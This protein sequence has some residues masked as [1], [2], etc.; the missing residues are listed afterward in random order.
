MSK[1]LMILFPEKE[2]DTKHIC[3]RD[4]CPLFTGETQDGLCLKLWCTPPQELKQL[5]KDGCI[6]NFYD[7][8]KPMI[9]EADGVDVND[10]LEKLQNETEQEQSEVKLNEETII[11]EFRVIR[12]KCFNEGIEGWQRE[13]LIARHFYEL[14]LNSK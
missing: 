2:P 13:K 10:I 1:T 4:G 7:T 5:G 12:D 6:C 9:V 8:T 14:G 11:K 3:Y